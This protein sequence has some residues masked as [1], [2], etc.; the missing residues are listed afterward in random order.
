MS[1]PSP[2]P[3]LTMRGVQKAFGATTALRG[4]DFSI[5]AGSIHA[6]IG[7]NGAGKSTLMR[8]LAG[9]DFADAGDMTFDGQ[10]YLPASPLAARARG[11]CTI[12]QDLTLALDLSVMENILLG[13]EPTRAGGLWLD[14]REMR[15]V[16]RRALDEVG[17]EGIAPET[18]AGDLSPAE[19][20]LVEIARAVAV[21][22]PGAGARR[23]D[24][25]AH[26][27]R[28]ENGCLRWC[29]GCRRAAWR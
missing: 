21:G 19:Q 26:A 10:P 20:Q 28:R 5:E 27:S 15:A 22:L 7:E 17:H 12:Y 16:A 29:G 8:I 11:V 9:A 13:S 3:L 24:Q 1:A 6:L 23:A 2:V 14:R 25:F 4:V 18:V